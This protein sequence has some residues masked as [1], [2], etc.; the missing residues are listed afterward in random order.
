LNK[1]LKENPDYI[2]PEGYKKIVEK[3]VKFYH[4]VSMDAF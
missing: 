3:K 1:Q 2:L 4:E